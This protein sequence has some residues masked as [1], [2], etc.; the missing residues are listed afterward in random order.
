M[1]LISSDDIRRIC[2]N[3][4][5]AVIIASQYAKKLNS[6]R[7]AKLQNE[8]EFEEE[9]IEKPKYKITTQALF[10]LVDGKIKFKRAE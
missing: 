7:I 4:Y 2:K 10:D 3:N 6:M 9:E 5:E 8:D 1:R